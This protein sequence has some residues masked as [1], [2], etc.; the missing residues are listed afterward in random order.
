MLVMSGANGAKSSS[1]CDSMLVGDTAAANTYPYIQ[2]V[3][4]LEMFY[5]FF[6][7]LFT[8]S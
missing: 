7:I 4:F 5:W 1:Q 8:S 2:V 3:T 6:V